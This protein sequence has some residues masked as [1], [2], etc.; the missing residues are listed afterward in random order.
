[1]KGQKNI[2]PANGNDKKV[3]IAILIASKMNF[4][5]NVIRKDKERQCVMIKGFICL[6]AC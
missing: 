1:M 5:R 6:C 2:F 4:K 3:G